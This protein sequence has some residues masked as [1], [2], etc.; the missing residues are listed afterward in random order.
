MLALMLA[1]TGCAPTGDY[2]RPRPNVL[3]DD[4]MPVA[5]EFAARLR[6]EPVSRFP[7]TDAEQDLR[8][9]AWALVMPQL[10]QQ[11]MDSFFAELRRTRL[12][13]AASTP[14]DPTSYGRTLLRTS[15]A[16]SDARFNRIAADAQI[17]RSN[18]L[19][20]IA[21]ARVVA[22][23]DRVRLGALANVIGTN[24][25]ER[26]NALARIDEN[27]AIIAWVRQSI[28]DRAA[29]Y[30]YAYEHLLIATPSTQAL[31]AERAVQA[32]EADLATLEGLVAPPVVVVE[33][34][35]YTK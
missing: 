33:Q 10:P 27:R 19:H 13:S 22:E 32:L 18:L 8:N 28:L 29:G 34:P 26:Q 14:T 7:H 3:H 17:D 4:I 30:R 9:Q 2:G 6:G 24:T 20:F 16:S 15:Y 23:D 21:T 1:A 25:A 5:G 11:R 35:I 12:L 31:A